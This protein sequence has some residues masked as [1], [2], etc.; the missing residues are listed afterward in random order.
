MIFNFVFPDRSACIGN[1]LMYQKIFFILMIASKMF[2]T[3]YNK[4]LRR[5]YSEP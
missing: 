2:I 5:R 3:K 4:A 1:S